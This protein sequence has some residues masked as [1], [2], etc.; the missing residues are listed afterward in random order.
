MGALLNLSVPL[1]ILGFP[2]LVETQAKLV[3]HI[4]YLLTPGQERQSKLLR[5]RRSRRCLWVLITRNPLSICPNEPRQ[6]LTEFIPEDMGGRRLLEPCLRLLGC[7]GG[8]GGEGVTTL[9]AYCGF[10]NVTIFFF[11]V[12]L[13]NTA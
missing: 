5:P 12:K 8:R 1:S 13:C 6:S 2:F 11:Y 3:S 9:C 10:I 4:S 7:G